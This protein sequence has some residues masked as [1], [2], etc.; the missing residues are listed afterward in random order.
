MMSEASFKK[1]AS[2][3]AGKIDENEVQLEGVFCCSQVEN[4]S[5]YYFI[6]PLEEGMKD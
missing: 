6:Y 2:F 1:I 5:V 3:E 4:E